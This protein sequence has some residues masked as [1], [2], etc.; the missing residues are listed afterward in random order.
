V[1]VCQTCDLESTSA[2]FHGRRWWLLTPPYHL[3]FWARTTLQR[4]LEENGFA[5]R[6]TTH[7]GLHPLENHGWSTVWDWLM[8][9]ERYVGWRFGTPSIIIVTATVR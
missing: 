6:H 8:K 1:F 3:I 9:K 7:E 4:I 2:R 5:I